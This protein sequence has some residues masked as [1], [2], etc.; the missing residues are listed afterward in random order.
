MN[1]RILGTIF[2]GTLNEFM[3]L[4]RSAWLEAR[5]FLQDILS[6]KNPLLR[7]NVELRNKA[8]VKQSDATMHL[9]VDIGLTVSF[10]S[11]KATFTL[12]D[13]TD[14]YSSI[15]HATNCGIIFRGK[16]NALLENW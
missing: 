14:F 15:H 4:N 9:R 8:F 2:K 10:F 6:A 12:G 7:D 1:P 5:S 11:N 3:G 16:E 13:Y